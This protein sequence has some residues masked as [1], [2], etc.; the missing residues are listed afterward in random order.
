MLSQPIVLASHNLGKLQE[1]SAILSPLQIE[2]ISQS[3]LNISEIEETGL[4]FVE[5]AI[6]KARHAARYTG[7]AAIADDSGLEVDSLNGEP[8]IYSARYAGL[9]ASDQ[10]NLEKLLEMLKETPETQRHARYQCFIVYMHHWQDPT[11]LICQGT[12]EGHILAI[13]QGNGGFG[14]DPI[15]YLPNH[16]CTAAQLSAAEKNRYSHRG[17]ALTALLTALNYK[18]N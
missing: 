18:K 4:S 11:P 7:L 10:Q 6:I 15:F 14:Y 9:G 1:I 17:K 12:W 13:P 3:K 5:N 2:L 8:G 16:Q